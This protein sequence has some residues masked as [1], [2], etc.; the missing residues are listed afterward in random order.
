MSVR[1]LRSAGDG[2]CRCPTIGLGAGQDEVGGGAQAGFRPGRRV[3]P[4]QT[5]LSPSS[6]E[7]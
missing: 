4:G 5:L 3:R 2:R 6:P 1:V 7:A